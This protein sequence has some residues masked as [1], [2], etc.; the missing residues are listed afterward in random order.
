VE[1][2]PA[3]RALVGGGDGGPTAS[4]AVRRP[5]S[6]GVCGP[7]T[8][9]LAVLERV[10]ALLGGHGPVELS[11]DEAESI[12]D[13]PPQ[14][15]RVTVRSVVGGQPPEKALAGPKALVDR[16]EVL[17]AAPRAGVVRERVWSSVSAPAASGPPGVG[18]PAGTGP[19]DRTVRSTGAAAEIVR[20]SGTN[21]T[22]MGLREGALDRLPKASS[23]DGAFVATADPA[24]LLHTS[25]VR[26]HMPPE[27]SAV[28]IRTELLEHGVTQLRDLAG[29]K[30]PVGW[31][32]AATVATAGRRVA[33]GRRCNR[34]GSVTSCAWSCASTVGVGGPV[35][36]HRGDAAAGFAPRSRQLRGWRP[37]GPGGA[38]P[39][40]RRHCGRPG[41]RPRRALAAGASLPPG[42]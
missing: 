5:S 3:R 25:A 4:F 9:E 18:F 38:E 11:L 28:F 22:S 20:W 27:A 16:G 31:L 32:D 40:V 30:D 39:A 33:N 8:D 23:F 1:R 37:A 17:K 34:S 19:H 26:R 42:R 6:E 29:A 21:A 12:V 2:V 7:D 35:C 14:S 24:T 15:E 10:V 41:T 13:A 36:L